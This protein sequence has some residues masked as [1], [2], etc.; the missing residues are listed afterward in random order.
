MKTIL[1]N[2]T[3][4]TTTSTLVA[5]FENDYPDTDD[6]HLVERLYRDDEAPYGWEYFLVGRGGPGT[7]YG[8]INTETARAEDGVAMRRITHRDAKNWLL[9]RGYHETAERELPRPPPEE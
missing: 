3:Y 7:E 8:E 2:H 9:G 1:G 6:R 4:D 5:T